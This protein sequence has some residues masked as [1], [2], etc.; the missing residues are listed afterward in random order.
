MQSGLPGSFWA[1]AISTANYIR[2]RTPCSSLD[3]RTPYEVW[4]GRKPDVSHFREFGCNAFCLNTEP[5]IGKFD[6]RGKPAIFLGYS[7][8][9]KGYRM[10]LVEEKKILVSRDVTF[11][12]NPG[13]TPTMLE[14]VFPEDLQQCE[15]TTGSSSENRTVDIELT[16]LESDGPNLE[17]DDSEID[18]ELDDNEEIPQRQQR[19][20]PG[21]PRVIR[22]GQRG[23]PRLQ[24]QPVREERA[25]ERPSFAGLVEIPVKQAM[26]SEDAEGWRKAISSEVKS[27]L[28]HDTW[29]L[30]ERPE[31]K[32]VIGSRFVLRNKYNSDGTLERK[33]AR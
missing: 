9:S 30:V 19:R 2:N 7:E 15:E 18:R 25:E 11:I 4:T 21:R 17:H 28:K 20:G 27:I 22:T 6:P 5:G 12:D 16:P 26:C 13:S 3:G 24:Y 1:E 8:S 32:E 14:D 33:K 29:W 31:N 23:R 10:W